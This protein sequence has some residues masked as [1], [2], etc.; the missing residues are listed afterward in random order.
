MS[1]ESEIPLRAE[2]SEEQ[3]EVN[4]TGVSV[5]AGECVCQAGVSGQEK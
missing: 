4:V 3:R 2:G 5:C 1:V